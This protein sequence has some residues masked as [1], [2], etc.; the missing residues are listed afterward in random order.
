M[1]PSVLCNLLSVVFLSRPMFLTAAYA[2]VDWSK[3]D[4][5][6]LEEQWKVGDD[7]RE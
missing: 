1:G 5:D 4:L 7:E 3:L 6:L 2:K